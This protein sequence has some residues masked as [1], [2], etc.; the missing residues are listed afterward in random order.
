[1]N[2]DTNKVPFQLAFQK[3]MQEAS[4]NLPKGK[5]T[6]ETISSLRNNFIKLWYSSSLKDRFPNALFDRQQALA[7]NN[8]LLMYDNWLFKFYEEKEF[9]EW[10][11]K[12]L[13][14]LKRFD[15]WFGRN[16]LTLTNDNYLSIDR[17]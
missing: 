8:M 7:E 15:E 10:A 1:M 2:L 17:Y 14:D 12:N 4:K 3:I 6:L 9:N 16:P 13:K 11:N 5:P